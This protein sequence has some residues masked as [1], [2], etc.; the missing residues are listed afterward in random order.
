MADASNHK[1]RQ[2]SLTNRTVVTIVG[3]G[4]LGT[5]FGSLNG[6]GTVALF[7]APFGVAIN[8]LS[9]TLF[10]ADRS[11]N[12]IRAI[13]P[14]RSV[15]T[16]SGGGDPASVAM[17]RGIFNGVGTSA[18]FSN[19]TSTAVGP[20]GVVYVAD[21]GTNRIRAVAP[22]GTVTTLAGG[23]ANLAASGSTDG[24]GTAAL[25]STPYGVAVNAS[26]HAFVADFNNRKIRLIFPDAR[27]ATLAGSGVIG[28][29]D[30]TGAAAQFNLPT[31]I[32]LGASGVAYVV[33][34]GNHKI[35]AVLPNATVVTVAGCC[36]NGTA[37]F[38][39]LDGVGT[40]ALF[41]NPLGVAVSPS[42][43][44][45]V[46]DYANHR[47]RAISAA[48]V[49]TTIAGGTS[50]GSTNGVGTNARFYFPTGVVVD[51][52]GVIY[53]AEASNNLI[54][55]ISPS[56]V[57]TTLAGSVSGSIN[58]VGTNALF[59]GPNGLSVDAA[60]VVYVAD[61]SNYKIRTITPAACLPGWYLPPGMFYCALCPDGTFS[62]QY[63]ATT[64]ALCPGGH[65]CPAGT[66]S[67]ASL[68][69]GR[70]S[71]C[72][73]GSAAPTSCP[74]QVPPPPYASWAQHPAGVQG[75]AF[76]VET[77]ACA[78]HCF[79]NFTSGDGQLSAC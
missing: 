49:V 18:S 50:S 73:D 56:L 15:T 17:L 46:A 68:N 33:D 79:W 19:P 39:S 71:Y 48:R 34:Y 14:S 37:I 5:T 41:Y 9:G 59:N 63:N 4:P 69:C 43:V 44:V 57:V 58:G 36:P 21:S 66:S 52:A 74:L 10:V 11:N 32:A 22:D 13:S 20:G 16:F 6:A 7:Y 55:M 12:I 64:C 61:T 2:F 30:G 27:V 62:K 8:P 26:G 29:A 31:A 1:I 72:P 53:V 24:M 54:R 60:G 76:L 65:Y 51:A 75:P 28:S 3:G 70:G 25:F 40:N 42:G 78:N 23:G 47:I 38:G 67:W 77:A 35:R 45:I